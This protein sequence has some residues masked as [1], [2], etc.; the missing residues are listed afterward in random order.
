MKYIAFEG[1]DGSGKTTISKMFVDYLI[2]QNFSV[3]HTKEPYTQ[4]IDLLIRK[5]QT[6]KSL[7]FLFLADRSIHIEY[8]R[9]QHVDFIVSD[10]S[11]YS[12]IAYQGFGA[13]MDVDFVT[14][15][16]KFVIDGFFPDAVFYL[17]CNTE[18]ALNR[19]KK[20]DAIEDKD[21]DFFKRVR[22]GYL[23]LAKEY[24]FYTLNSEETPQKVFL[25]LL[26]IYERRFK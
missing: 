17:D 11:F 21:L 9:K 18:L 12:T 13:N 19:I 7:L 26:E 22:Q 1:I 3:L 20:G 6:S 4:E 25:N 24:N 15:L 10:R 14:M 8:L 2:K 23:N 5:Q 16:N